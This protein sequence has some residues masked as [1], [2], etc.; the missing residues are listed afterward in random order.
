MS[1]LAFHCL[2]RG[3]PTWK[4]KGLL[5]L[6]QKWTAQSSEREVEVEEKLGIGCRAEGR[7]GGESKEERKGRGEREAGVKEE[8]QLGTLPALSLP[9]LTQAQLSVG[10]P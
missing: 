7:Q 6:R 9:G 3:D 10:W 2:H 8:E 4:G 1:G 5:R